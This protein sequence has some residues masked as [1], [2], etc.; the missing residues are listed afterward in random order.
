MTL[1]ELLKIFLSSILDHIL[2]VLELDGLALYDSLPMLNTFHQVLLYQIMFIVKLDG[3]APFM[4]DPP[5]T[6]STTQQ[7]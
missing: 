2:T 4:T 6:S 5:P 1:G 7:N 3:V